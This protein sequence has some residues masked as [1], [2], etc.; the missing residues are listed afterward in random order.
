VIAATPWTGAVMA[1]A[2]ALSACDRASES[3]YM[4]TPEQDPAM[5]AAIAEARA[6]LPVF[7]AKYDAAQDKSD[8]L[9]KAG[10]KDRYGGREHIW[11]YLDGRAGESV[12]GRL[13]NKPEYLDNLQLGSPVVVPVADLSDWAYGRDGKYYG[14][15]TT[16]GLLARMTPAQRAESEAILAPTPL[17]PKTH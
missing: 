17:E 5:D 16:R 9:I 3:T 15:Y 13:A 6:S 11:I 8:F 7:W 14:M 4:P 12:N 2:V 1:A 10:M